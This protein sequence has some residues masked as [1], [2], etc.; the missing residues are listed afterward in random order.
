MKRKLTVLS[1]TL[2]LGLTFGTTTAFASN[3]S[4][5]TLDTSL[6]SGN[7]DLV[8]NEYNQKPEVE[9]TYQDFD[10]D[11]VEKIVVVYAEENDPF[12][13]E[14]KSRGIEVVYEENVLWRAGFMYFSNITWITRDGVVSLSVTPKSPG[15]IAKEESWQELIRYFQYHPFYTQE[16][17][18]TKFNSLRNQYLCHVDFARQ[19][20]TPWNIEPS[21]PDKGYWGFVS[22][23]C[24]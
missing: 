9:F 23:L 2:V 21:K 17:N 3:T 1:M 22:G 13:E 18:P 14:A 7:L 12:I 6:T 24:N 11:G 4:V 20:K 19:F 16:T 5:P 10:W 15:S 8:Q